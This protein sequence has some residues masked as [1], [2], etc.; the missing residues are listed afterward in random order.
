[1]YWQV[2]LHKT[3]VSRR[4]DAGESHSQ[5]TSVGS[6]EEK[7]SRKR[8]VDAVPLEPFTIDTFQK[9]P[10]ALKAF[11]EMDDHDIWGAIK[12][13]KDHDDRILSLLVPHAAE[14]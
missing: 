11:G 1:M 12:L 9:N 14:S 10:R 4:A 8:I 2:Y 13:W 6:G 3:S 7:K 5:R